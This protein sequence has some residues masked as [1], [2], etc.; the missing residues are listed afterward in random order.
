MIAVTGA[1]VVV[2]YCRKVFRAQVIDSVLGDH[3]VENMIAVRREDHHA[4]RLQMTRKQR[5]QI[6]DC[7]AVKMGDKRAP[8]T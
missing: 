8:P 3:A 6:V 2:S 5:K 4:I 7:F 1:T